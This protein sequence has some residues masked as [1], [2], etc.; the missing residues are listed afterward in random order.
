LCLNRPVLVH[1]DT[2]QIC[3]IGDALN[4]DQHIPLQ[5]KAGADGQVAHE[6]VRLTEIKPNP[7]N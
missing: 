3:W 1:A 5:I 7:N 2:S 6:S 4:H